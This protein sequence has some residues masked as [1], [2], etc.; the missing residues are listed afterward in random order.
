MQ[1]CQSSC[2]TMLR[3]SIATGKK[4]VSH[5]TRWHMKNWQRLTLHSSHSVTKFKQKSGWICPLT[6]SYCES[7]VFICNIPK[8]T[9]ND[10]EGLHSVQVIPIAALTVLNRANW[11]ISHVAFMWLFIWWLWRESCLLSALCGVN[12]CRNG[13]TGQFLHYSPFPPNVW[14]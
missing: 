5:R 8:I 10:M 6:Q 13:L 9:L 1:Y 4:R 11:F 12:F 3:Y 7:L 14:V 2:G